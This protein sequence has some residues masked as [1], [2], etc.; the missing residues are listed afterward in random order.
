MKDGALIPPW[1]MKDGLRPGTLVA[2][3]AALIVYHFCGASPSTV[4]TPILLLDVRSYGSNRFSRSK[5]GGSR[6]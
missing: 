2:I 3:E 1:E 5:P 4:C 6:S